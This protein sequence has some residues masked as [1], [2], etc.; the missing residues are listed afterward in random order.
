[1]YVY[2]FQEVAKAQAWKAQIDIY[3]QQ[4][5]ELHKK[6]NEETKRADKLD[7]ENKKVQDQLRA[8]KREKEV[9]F[10]IFNF[11]DFNCFCHVYA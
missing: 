4:V 3:K 9:R 5:A 11:S 1:M 10:I 8:V 6:L 2:I 7:F